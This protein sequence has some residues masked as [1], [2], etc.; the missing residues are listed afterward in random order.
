MIMLCGIVFYLVCCAVWFCVCEWSHSLIHSQ[1]E[2]VYGI[3][4]R[5]SNSADQFKMWCCCTFSCFIFFSSSSF[6]LLFSITSIWL[7]IKSFASHFTWKKERKITFYFWHKWTRKR[8]NKKCLVAG[9]G[10]QESQRWPIEWNRKRWRWRERGGGR[11]IHWMRNRWKSNGHAFSL[12][13]FRR[14]DT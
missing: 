2:F 6:F 9:N 14:T 7:H 1:Y 3:V 5:N 10:R 13:R 8:E 12:F 4:K 11:V